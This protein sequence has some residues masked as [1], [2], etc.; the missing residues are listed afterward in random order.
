MGKGGK[1]KG[2]KG[3]GKPVFDEGPPDRVEALGLSMHVCEDQ[4]I[5]KCTNARVP[6]FNA[7]IFLENKEHIGNLDEIFGPINDFMFSVKMMD[8]MK[9]A[10]FK[11]DSKVY[12]DPYKT[13]PFDRFL[14]QKPGAKGGKGKGKGKKGGDKGKGKGKKGGDKGKGKGGKK[15]V[16]KG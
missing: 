3:K 14:P 13:L 2:G 7:R 10:S 1:G 16:K 9:A 11:K 6:Q 12:I 15:G 8:G 5:C 4:L